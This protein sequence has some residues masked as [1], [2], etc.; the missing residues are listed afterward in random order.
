MIAFNTGP[1]METM[2]LFD[3]QWEKGTTYIETLQPGSAGAAYVAK[4]ATK[5]MTATSDERL[6]G[7]HPEFTRMSQRPPIGAPFYRKMLDMLHTESGSYLL[8]RQ[9]DVPSLF[10]IDRIKFTV[11]PYWKKWLRKE[12]GITDPSDAVWGFEAD[13]NQM[14]CIDEQTKT[15][16]IE[17]AKRWHDKLK[18]QKTHNTPRS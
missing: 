9:K 18:R 10:T 5:S 15:I 13:I 3:S 8:A 16:E 11:D 2:Q 4:Y 7:R 17:Q 1:Q 14:E 6:Y 12:I